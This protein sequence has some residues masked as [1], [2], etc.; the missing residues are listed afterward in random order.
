[1][2]DTADRILVSLAALA[3]LVQESVVRGP[4]WLF[5][6]LGRRWERAHLVSAGLQAAFA[7]APDATT[8]G[9]LGELVLAANESLIAYR[10]RYRTD[11]EP[12]PLF[13]LLVTDPSNPRSLRFQLT[14][15]TATIAE[16]PNQP[17]LARCQ[18]F[19]TGALQLLDHSVS[20]ATIA[21][22]TDELSGTLN[23][24]NSALS[25]AWFTSVVAREPATP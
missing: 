6:D 25:E 8:V 14:Q 7:G 15:M 13:E 3:G 22:V 16:L 17:G 2:S 21:G 1:V 24:L 9:P 5:L 10:R 20:L 4:G 11:V 18:G 19:A 23:L 12:E